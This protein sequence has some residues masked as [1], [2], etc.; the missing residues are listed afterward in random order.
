MDNVYVD[1]S[2]LPGLGMGGAGVT[3]GPGDVR[4]RAICLRGRNWGSSVGAE[5]AAILLAVD[6]V[7]RSPYP[8]GTVVFVHSD[9]RQAIRC[10][11]GIGRRSDFGQLLTELRW[12][13][14]RLYQAGVR[15][16]VQWESRRSMGIRMAHNLARAAAQTAKIAAA[17]HSFFSVI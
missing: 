1:G 17:R 10:V 6:A 9:C 5:L 7:R 2:W 11:N 12:K 8:R 13:M 14:W 15:V 4:N 16:H 3:F